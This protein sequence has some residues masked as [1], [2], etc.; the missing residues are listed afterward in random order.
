MLML[1][2][3]KISTVISP[4]QDKSVFGEKVPLTEKESLKRV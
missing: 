2:E 3:S 1:V 4:T